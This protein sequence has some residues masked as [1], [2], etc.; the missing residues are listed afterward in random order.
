MTNKI[1]TDQANRFEDENPDE[2][3]ADETSTP[4]PQTPAPA[5]RGR[6]A[7]PPPA[8][9]D[10]AP[11]PSYLR[12]LAAMPGVDP[13][14]F[15]N[16]PTGTAWVK[17]ESANGAARSMPL[18][19][20]APDALDT[21]AELGF[22]GHT[23]FEIRE[24]Q[25]GRVLRYFACRLDL[26]EP[27]PATTDPAA[28][29]AAGNPQLIEVLTRQQMQLNALQAKLDGVGADPLAGLEKAFAMFDRFSRMLARAMPAP[30]PAA[31]PLIDIAA[32]VLP[33]LTRQEAPPADEPP[34]EPQP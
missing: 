7:A 32:Q 2:F 17:I 5:T 21:L 20:L 22:E 25:A 26:L 3:E 27:D 29:G 31:N 28:P 9:H 19:H 12:D 13:E 34:Q 10:P 1:P 16:V 15:E 33:L 14:A 6:R 11:V 23:T 24:T 4:E 18:A 8:Q 30:A